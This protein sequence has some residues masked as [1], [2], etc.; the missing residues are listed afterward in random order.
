MRDLV[1]IGSGGI[2]KELIWLISDINAIEKKWNIIGFLDDHV[3]V[4]TRIY[5]GFEVLGNVEWLANHKADVVIGIGDPIVRQNIYQKLKSYN[6]NFPIIKHPQA[7]CSKDVVL[8][9]GSII[10]PGVIISVNVKLGQ[11][12]I[13]NNNVT[14]GHDTVIKA[15]CTINPCSNVAGN[16]TIEDYAYLGSSSAILQNLTIGNSSVI[17]AGAIVINDIP[18]KVTV[19]GVPAKKLIK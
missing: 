6:L 17:G 4:G 16:V 5:E 18:E 15:F 12:G 13:L 8:G 3:P 2:G 1:V 10:Y 7:V 14:I 19:V 9:Q 11:F